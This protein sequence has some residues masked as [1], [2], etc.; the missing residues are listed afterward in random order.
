MRGD[1]SSSTLVTM[2]VYFYSHPCVRGDN[3]N[4]EI[5]SFVFNFYSHPCVRGDLPDCENISS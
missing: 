2:P 1:L 4:G 5:A 3:K